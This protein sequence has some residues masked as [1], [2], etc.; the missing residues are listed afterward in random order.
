VP[1]DPANTS[2][3]D[4]QAAAEGKLL[5]GAPEDPQRALDEFMA[6]TDG[7]FR[8]A[9]T[10]VNECRVV[11]EWAKSLCKFNNTCIETK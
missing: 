8:E 4:I 9:D 5:P 3:G 10:V 1:N 2:S 11:Y 7:A 6:G